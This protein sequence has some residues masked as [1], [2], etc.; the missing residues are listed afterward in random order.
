MIA[1]VAIVLG[2][3]T[4]LC[5]GVIANFFHNPD[6]RGVL[7]VLSVSIV[8]EG[9]CVAPD[10]LLQRQLRMRAVAIREWL[11]AIFAGI[12]ALIAALAGAGYWSLVVQ[13]MVNDVVTLVVLLALVGR[14]PLRGSWQTVKEISGFSTKVF[15]TQFLSFSL[16]NSDNLLVGR[17]LGSAQ[18]AYYSISYRT[19]MLP[20]QA[21]AVSS[22]RVTLPVYS[23]LQGHRDRFHRA[24]LD[25]AVHGCR[26]VGCTPRPRGRLEAGRGAHPDLGPGRRLARRDGRLRARFHRSR[27]GKSSSAVPAP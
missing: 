23:R 9:L 4:A 10:S 5:A 22:G 24:F 7:R 26:S 17:F 27:P 19:M 14:L 11:A 3:L 1:L 21:L 18:L 16:R 12:V 13:V 15:L 2:G 8:L 25:V 20:V 6:L